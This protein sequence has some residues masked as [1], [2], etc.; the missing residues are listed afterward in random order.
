MIIEQKAPDLLHSMLIAEE[1]RDAAQ[2]RQ[3]EALKAREQLVQER[4]AG[5]MKENALLEE[6]IPLLRGRIKQKER[7]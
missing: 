2:A 1:G 7:L 4:V 3:Q 5:L 6:Q